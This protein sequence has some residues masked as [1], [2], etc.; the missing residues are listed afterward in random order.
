MFPIGGGA[1]VAVPPLF[2]G[3]RGGVVLGLLLWFGGFFMVLSV[4]FCYCSATEWP[5]FCLK[6]RWGWV[7]GVF[8]VPSGV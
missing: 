7:P 1:G 3:V 4:L 5:L 2:S 8:R 6:G